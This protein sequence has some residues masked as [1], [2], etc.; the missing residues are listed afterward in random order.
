MEELHNE[1]NNDKPILGKDSLFVLARKLYANRKLIYRN[2][3]IGAVLG[4]IFALGV[5]KTWTSS[6]VLA[7]EM[8]TEAGL[9]GK[10]SGLAALAGLNLGAGSTD[11]I[12]PELYPQMIEATPFIVGLLDVKVETLDGDVETTLYDYMVN[13]QKKT[14][15]GTV[16]HWIRTGVK[17]VTSL[18]IKSKFKESS[19]EIDPFYL[20]L[21]QD[22]IVESVRNDMVTT[23]VNKS[24]LLITLSVT[25]QDPLISATLVD[26]VRERLQREIIT[27]RTQ[28]ARHD[29]EYYQS[30]VE[31]A[32]VEYKRLEQLYAVYSDEHQNPF[33][34]TVKAERD[35]L[36]NQMQIAYNVYS[37]MVQQYELS[38]AKV[39]EATPSFT[40]IQPAGVSVKPSS[41]PKIVVALVW[42]FLLVFVTSG[43][44]L[45]RDTLHDWKQ[46]IT[47]PQVDVE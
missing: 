38:K 39:Q 40:I 13:Y 26:S 43:W 46:K 10:F 9:S 12:Y 32:R 24:D 17:A 33:L 16:K 4:V 21:D 27:Y 35:D 31:E 37:Q 30:L 14:W 42:I 28:K 47:A 29:M 23:F 8:T 7:P 5:Q 44:I 18:F 1:Q 25:T 15:L 11:A 20:S 41:T 2:A 6:V 19:D 22:V 3:I 45:V 34:T 36:E